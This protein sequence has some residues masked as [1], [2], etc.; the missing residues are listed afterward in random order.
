MQFTTRI[1]KLINI[2]FENLGEPNTRRRKK[3]RKNGGWTC[4]Y[5]AS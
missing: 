4:Y 2:N 5:F 3:K 1:N